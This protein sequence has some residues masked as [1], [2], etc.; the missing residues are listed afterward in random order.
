MKILSINE[1]RKV[2]VKAKVLIELYSGTQWFCIVEKVE[3]NE[4]HL[5][6]SYFPKLKVNF[7]SIASLEIIP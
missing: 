6:N 3:K 1:F 2:P 4:F 7:G 5:S